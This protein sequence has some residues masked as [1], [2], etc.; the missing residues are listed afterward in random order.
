M[1][2]TFQT[3]YTP[4]E[5]RQRPGTENHEE[6]MTQQSDMAEC[7]INVIMS[8]YGGTGQLPQVLDHPQYGDFTEVGDFRTMVETVRA[9]EEAFAGLPAKVRN[10][11]HND[12]EEMMEFLGDPDNRDEAVKLGL[13]NAPPPT[14][15]ADT[16]PTP[17]YQEAYD[18]N[19]IQQ[20]TAP[21]GSANGPRGQQGR[22][23]GPN[24]PRVPEGSGEPEGRPGQTAR[25]QR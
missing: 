8:K 7:D 13:V 9:A 16:A 3:Q 23:G 4:T 22:P 20:R 10:R 18:D 25:P 15:N 14:D 5:E 1:N 12:P 24:G 2:I 17:H 6:D 19:G 21:A 11:F